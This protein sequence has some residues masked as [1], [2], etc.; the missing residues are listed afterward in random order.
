MHSDPV[1]TRVDWSLHKIFFLPS[2]E[3][4]SQK[5]SS[6]S[7]ISYIKVVIDQHGKYDIIMH[8]VVLSQ[9]IVHVKR[10]DAADRIL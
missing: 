5:L 10:V 7:F 8:W 4:Q 9:Q 2:S 3:L 6:K 1:S